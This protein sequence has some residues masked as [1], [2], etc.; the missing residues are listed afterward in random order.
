VSVLGA[1]VGA[2]ALGA[3]A[4]A[5]LMLMF[6]EDHPADAAYRAVRVAVAWPFIV[7][8]LVLSSPLYA[9]RLMMPRRESGACPECAKR[10][11]YR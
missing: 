11:P 1:A 3:L 2:W 4:T 10:G 6:S 5:V 9:W 8:L 7:G